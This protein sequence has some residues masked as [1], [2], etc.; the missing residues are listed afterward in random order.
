MLP[1]EDDPNNLTA[2]DKKLVFTYDYLNRRV[3]KLV[4]AWDPEEGEGGDW[5]STAELDLRFIY[6]ERLLLLELDGLDSNAKVRKHVWGPG[7]DGR[8]GGLNSLL[9]TRDI[10]STTN[11]V[12]FNNGTGSVAQLLD[13]SDG[14]VDAKYV[15][16]TRGDTVRNT[17]TYAADNAL[18]YHAMYFDAEFD[19]A[20]TTCDGLYCSAHGNYYSPRLARSLTPVLNQPVRVAHGWAASL[21]DIDDGSGMGP[22]VSFGTSGSVSFPPGDVPGFP[23]DDVVPPPPPHPTAMVAPPTPKCDR[24]DVESVESLQGPC[25]EEVSLVQCTEMEDALAQSAQRQAGGAGTSRISGASSSAIRLGSGV[26]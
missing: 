20:G 15:Y 8:L 19:Y 14:S 9:G 17:G 10:H 4:Y 22:A 26:A 23:A 16:D 7:T 25:R 12:C 11:Y 13:R 5:S 2:D 3:R 6:H 24:N 18:R 1:A 21:R